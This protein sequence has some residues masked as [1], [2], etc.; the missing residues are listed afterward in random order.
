MFKGI[1]VSAYQGDID[2]DKLKVDFVIIRV[3]WGKGTIDK[4]FKRNIEMCNKK[5]I[6]CGVYWFS[7]A[8]NPEG[9]KKEAEACLAAIAPYKITYPVCFDFEYD[10]VTYAAK[11]GV[12]VTKKLAS[13]IARAFLSR[14]EAAGYWAMNYTNL[15]FSKRY[16]DEQVMTKYDVWAARY[17]K[18]ETDIAVTA[19][20]WQYSSKGKVVGISG[21]VDM[22]ISHKDYPA[23][24]KA[25]GHTVSEK[26]QDTPQLTIAKDS[27]KIP[28]MYRD[29]FDADQYY[30]RY[31]DLQE[32]I[33]ADG[34]KLFEHFCLYGMR[35][36][37]IASDFNVVKYRHS[38]PDL[39]A[40]FGDD[41]PAYYVHYMLAG[42]KEIAEGKRAQ[43]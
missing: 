5:G 42:K 17:T 1:D 2:Y 28:D 43:A 6:P 26:T 40:A 30:R 31:P 4:K 35:E 27:Y 13:D 24:I 29:I 25:K 41:W 37:R 20:I 19:G 23:L 3:G 11:K 22:D 33:G 34:Q 10:S 9:A 21:N 36:A 8:L 16:F 18:K 32:A 39:D 38:N 7:Y 12:T 15:D 14:I